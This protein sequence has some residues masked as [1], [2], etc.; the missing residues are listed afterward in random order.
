[1]KKWI[2]LVVM[3][4][5]LAGCSSGGAKENS[6]SEKIANQYTRQ[7]FQLQKQKHLLQKRK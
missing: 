5:A 4:A 7:K 6:K 2:V 1:M 3:I